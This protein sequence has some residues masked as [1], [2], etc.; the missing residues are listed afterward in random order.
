MGRPSFFRPILLC[1]PFVDYADLVAIEGFHQL[2]QHCFVSRVT[3]PS[4]AHLAQ[5]RCIHRR[6]TGQ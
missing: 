1:L 2:D 6:S 5:A 3:L 4:L